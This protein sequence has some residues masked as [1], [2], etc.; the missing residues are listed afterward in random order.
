MRKIPDEFK[1]KFNRN[2]HDT[3]L[4]SRTP[5][6]FKKYEKDK[7]QIIWK[8]NSQ[9]PVQG[10][11]IVLDILNLNYEFLLEYG[12]LVISAIIFGLEKDK[13]VDTFMQSTLETILAKIIG[14]T[15]LRFTQELSMLTKKYQVTPNIVSSIEQKKSSKWSDTLNILL[16]KLSE[17]IIIYNKNTES[18]TPT[19]SGMTLKKDRKDYYIN[20]QRISELKKLEINNFDFQKLIKATFLKYSSDILGKEGYK[21]TGTKIIRYFTA[22]SVEYDI[23][24]PFDEYPF[25]PKTPNKRTALLENLKVFP[26]EI[27]FE[28]IEELCNNDLLKEHQDVKKLKQ[29]LFERYSALST[30]K[31]EIN[32][33]LI[34]ETKTI[35]HNYPNA[36][37][38]FLSALEKFSKKIYERNLLDDMR[39]SL[40]LLLKNV[41]S[42]SKSLENQ[43]SEIGKFQKAKGS[44][45][46]LTNMF[47]KLVDY[48]TKYHNSKVKHNDNVNSDE[49]EIII[50]LT[51][52]FIKFLIKVSNKE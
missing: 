39:L 19:S 2:N 37:K 40:E 43:I 32:V 14:R 4:R 42:N 6:I 7:S 31:K 25:P 28:I 13:I 52:T 23:E 24:I 36:E 18:N 30:S 5:A 16:S 47:I 46:E 15:N 26:P 9:T 33:E 44:S 17:Q 3:F 41:L 10:H 51:S 35:L 27:Q 45:T 48:Y 34:N 12:E 20:P 8:F 50:E 49:L 21:F 38:P 22:K 11:F 1:T 29:Q